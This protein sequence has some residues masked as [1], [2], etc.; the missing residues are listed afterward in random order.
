MYIYIYLYI[1]IHIYIIFIYIYIYI[2]TRQLVVSYIYL[3]YTRV[4]RRNQGIFEILS[5]KIDKYL[6]SY[7][8]IYIFIYNIY[9]I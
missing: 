7:L 2:Y 1:Y 5:N 6:F 8:C 9:N 3:I 4:S